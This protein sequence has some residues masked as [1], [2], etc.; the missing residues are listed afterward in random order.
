MN[1]RDRSHED[2]EPFLQKTVGGTVN[3]CSEILQALPGA[4]RALGPAW[5]TALVVLLTILAVTVSHQGRDAFLVTMDVGSVVGSGRMRWFGFGVAILSTLLF[6]VMMIGTAFFVLAIDRRAIEASYNTDILRSSRG[7]DPLSASINLRTATALTLGLALPAAMFLSLFLRFAFQDGGATVRF[8]I[9]ILAAIA[10]YLTAVVID[11]Q[12]AHWRQILS[13]RFS[14]R[15]EKRPAV[16]LFRFLAFEGGRVAAFVFGKPARYF[17]TAFVALV[18]VIYCGIGKTGDRYEVAA[19]ALIV[20]MALAALMFKFVVNLI[21]TQH[22]GREDRYVIIDR[23]FALW[24]QLIATGMLVLILVCLWIWP[25]TGALGPVPVLLFGGS[26]IAIMLSWLVRKAM[27]PPSPGSIAQSGIPTFLNWFGRFEEWWDRVLSPSAILSL[28][29]GLL[30]LD[31]LI[32]PML[33]RGL[34]GDYLYLVVALFAIAAG[35]YL[36]M[37]SRKREKERIERRQARWRFPTPVLLAPFFLTG[38]GENH[39]VRIINGADNAVVMDANM[40]AEAWLSAAN[41][42]TDGDEDIPAIIVLAEGGG[43]RTAA[44]AGLLLSQ[45]EL[46][47]E[48]RCKEDGDTPASLDRLCAEDG[49]FRH[50]YAMSGVS[51]GSVGLAAYLS[52]RADVLGG[53]EGGFVSADDKIKQTLSKDLILPLFAGL[54]ASDLPTSLV[55]VQLPNRIARSV[56][57][58]IAH[59]SWIDDRAD[60][61]EDALIRAGPRD[62]YGVQWFSKPMEEVVAEAATADRVAPVV[63]FNTFAEETASPAAASNVTFDGCDGGTERKGYSGF[64]RVQ[65]CLSKRT[66]GTWSALSLATAAHMS[67]R[68]P[69]AS[70]TAVIEIRETAKDGG[71]VSTDRHFVDGGYFDSSGAAGAAH[72]ARALRRA[73]IKLGLEERL[74]PIVVNIYTR[75]VDAPRPSPPRAGQGRILSEISIP[76]GAVMGARNVSG[77]MPVAAL[78]LLV[79]RDLSVDVLR[80]CESLV[81][82]R[83][84]RRPVSEVPPDW[85]HLARASIACRA[86]VVSSALVDVYGDPQDTSGYDVAWINAPLDVAA[87]PDDPLVEHALLGWSLKRSTFEYIGGTAEDL[88]PKVLQGIESVLLNREPI[89]DQQSAGSSELSR[90]D[91]CSDCECRKYGQDRQPSDR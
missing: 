36:W 56:A 48:A 6:S 72:A 89:H 46:E 73:A 35:S 47:R 80:V 43:I 64:V 90:A 52:G 31:R 84:A 18:T 42:S 7:H 57:P 21:M 28:G 44:H 34:G 37:F 62:Q 78:C 91:D 13:Y 22:I 51:G 69:G 82:Y 55:P 40:H 45:L 53:V 49:F 25:V 15:T 26:A 67:A 79:A 32:V 77:Q 8:G 16:D 68:F 41:L 58:N 88:A 86:E 27:A 2:N 12:S 29:L 59:G 19:I 17:V 38:S 9:G 20:V 23:K 39:Y 4:I 30:V 83:T 5:P 3:A 74:Q 87:T 14:I 65:D 85:N 33:E 81:D 76:V 70:P 75:K 50:V 66:D 11:R 60:F 1:F 24:Y 54:F 10:T 71:N 63:L 61:F